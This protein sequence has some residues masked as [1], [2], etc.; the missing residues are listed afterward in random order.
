METTNK[1][2]LDAMQ[3]APQLTRAW[4]EVRMGKFTG[5][6]ISALFTEPRTKAEKEAGELSQT[7]R[8][9]I[10]GKV[11]ELATGLPADEVGGRAIDWGND[12]EEEA[13]IMVANYL[14][15]PMERVIFKPPFRLFNNYSGCSPDA[16]IW[17][18]QT[19]EDLG[20]DR[21]STR[22]NSSL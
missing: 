9:Y 5:S 6:Q 13:I 14:N 18:A 7:A 20:I 12:H 21:K 3:H 10:G 2:I 4:S 19:E 1:F 8:K 16:F 15:A 11:M 17:D 22:L